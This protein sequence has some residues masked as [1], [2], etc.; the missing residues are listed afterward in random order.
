MT[1]AAVWP[2]SSLSG[3]ARTTIRLSYSARVKTSGAKPDGFA[4]PRAGF[5]YFRRHTG[6]EF[7]S[8]VRGFF[9]N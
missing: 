5:I 3:Y 8:A 4:E 6:R 9:T 7:N 2:L 1:T